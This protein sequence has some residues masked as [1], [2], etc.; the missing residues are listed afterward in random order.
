VLVVEKGRLFKP[1][2]RAVAPG[3]GAET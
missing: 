3:A 1:H 2:A